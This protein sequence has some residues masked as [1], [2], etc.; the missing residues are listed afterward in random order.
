VIVIVAPSILQT[1]RFGPVEATDVNPWLPA[2]PVVGSGQPAWTF[3]TC[4]VTI[5]PLNVMTAVNV[6]VNCA[7]TPAVTDIV[8]GVSVA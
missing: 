1:G 6:K 4:R 3:G 5:P 7:T 8:T 2:G